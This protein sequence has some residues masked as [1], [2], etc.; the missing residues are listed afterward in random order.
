M[1]REL[2]CQKDGA[3]F[4]EGTTY[5][6]KTCLETCLCQDDGKFLCHPCLPKK[7]SDQCNG[8]AHEFVKVSLAD[9]VNNKKCHCFKYECRK[10]TFKSIVKSLWQKIKNKFGSNDGEDE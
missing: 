6:T 2:T 5:T 7:P 1:K 4:M 10:K 3:S 9:S 8:W